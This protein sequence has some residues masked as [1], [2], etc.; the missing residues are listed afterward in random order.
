MDSVKYI[1]MDVHKETISI[2]VRNSSGKF[3]SRRP[4]HSF[5]KSC[6]NFAATNEG[7]RLEQS[8][9]SDYAARL[10]N[11]SAKLKPGRTAARPMTYRNASNPQYRWRRNENESH[12]PFVFSCGGVCRAFLFCRLTSGSPGCPFS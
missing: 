5:Q 9:V 3:E 7:D 10:A 1:G 11:W 2:A 4:R 6:I 8:S 12:C